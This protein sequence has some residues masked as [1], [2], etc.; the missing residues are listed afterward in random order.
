MGRLNDGE[1]KGEGEV[2]ENGA[3]GMVGR[4]VVGRGVMGRGMVGR[5]MVKR[6]RDE[7]HM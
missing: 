5:E 7:Y 6:E 2:R 3:E 4:G 1:G